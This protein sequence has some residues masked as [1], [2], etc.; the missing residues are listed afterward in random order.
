ML[1]VGG[2][3]GP[4]VVDLGEVVRLVALDSQWWLQ[5]GPKPGPT[6]SCPPPL[7]AR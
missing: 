1:P 5:D 2:C 6:S 3:P 7:R 4:T